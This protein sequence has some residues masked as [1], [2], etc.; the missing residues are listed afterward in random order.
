MMNNPELSIKLKLVTGYILLVTLFVVVLSLI[1]CEHDNM[2]A[3]S[4]QAKELSEQRRQ[5]EQITIQLLDL[6]FQSEQMVGVREDDFEIYKCKRDSVVSSLEIL[7]LRLNNPAQCARID[8]V[9]FL[10]QAKEEHLFAILKNVRELRESYN[11]VQKRIPNIIRQTNYQSEDLSERLQENIEKGRKQTSG[12]KGLFRSKKKS[13]EQIEQENEI[14]LRNA[15]KRQSGTLRV[16]A[17]EI[18]GTHKAN[19]LRLI[20]HVDSL[21]VRNTYLNK[22]IRRLITEFGI[23]DLD[24]RENVIAKE[25]F[26]RKQAIMTI[27]V[28]SIVALLLAIVFYILLHRDIQERYRNRIRLERSNNRNE[29]LLAARKTMMLTVSHDLRAPLAA[30]N[31]YAELLP[32][33]RRKENRLRYTEAILQSS[34]RMLSLLN[35][36]L[37]YYRLD[38]GKEQPDSRPFRLQSLADALAA[39]YAPLAAKKRLE[40]TTCY[41]GEDVIVAGDRE[42]IL[43]IAGN[44][45][46]NAV[47]FT[48]T[49]TIRLNLEYG[50]G[51]LLLRVEDTGAGMTEEQTKRI[52]EPF[53]RLGN[54]E[55]EEGFG[56]GLSITLALVELLKGR[57]DV[58][59]RP[60]VGTTFTVHLPLPLCN[61]ENLSPQPTEPNALP[62]DLRVIVVENDAVLLAMTVEM[63]S[64][65]HIH[66]E[67]CHS[68][69]ELMECLRTQRYDLVLTDIMMPDVNGFGVLELLRT[70]NI[71]SA[72][73]VPVVAMTARVERNCE[74]FLR[75]GFAGC[76][77]KPFSRGELFATVQQCIEKRTGEPLPEADFSGLFSGERNDGEMLALVARETK[78]NMTVLADALGRDD[79]ESIAALTHQLLPLW[80]VLRIDAPLQ[81]LRKALCVCSSMDDAVR[82]AARE[83]LAAGER[84]IEQ[85]RR[86]KEGNG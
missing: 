34:G 41:N 76:L 22:Q 26:G 51:D 13:R 17:D 83:V 61:E 42:R 11:L 28:F 79:R 32:D 21:T 54:S 64:R 25:L 49:G 19:T 2:E 63:F 81:D 66:A 38:T 40:L 18:A 75:A 85:A 46:S 73:T 27:S 52:F 35:T 82:R 33:E 70:S 48:R 37:D 20:S 39:E 86:G 4:V 3:I 14:I 10:L 44:L 65:C 1:Y 57:I 5:T 78:R 68:A 77:Y 80:E 72:K 55:T 30:I 29:E 8:S 12:I 69:R 24:I 56:L 84:L 43:Q 71:P 53:E 62:T 58:Q 36:L 15:Q 6:S 31:G 50:S 16:L 23:A 47:K 9:L 59:S 67:S 45:L 74:E 60:G 7:R